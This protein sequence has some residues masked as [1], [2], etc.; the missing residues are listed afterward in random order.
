MYG[1]TWNE[2]KLW[3]KNFE[4]RLNTMC[5]RIQ[6]SFP[7]GCQIFLANI[8]D[9]SDGTGKLETP[10]ISLPAWPD[11]LRVLAAYKDAIARVAKQRGNVHLV[12]IHALFLGHG[13]AFADR[14]NPYYCRENPQ[15]WFYSNIEDPN[16]QG[17]D[18]LRRLFLSE[19]TK[20]RFEQ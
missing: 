19:M 9:P 2:T 6:Q 18:A 17:Y 1:A 10:T 20:V 5:D 11:G 15:Y 8:Y 7:G 13:E 3:V 4:Q 12:D 14:R 16:E